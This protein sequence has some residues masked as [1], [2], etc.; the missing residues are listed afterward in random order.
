MCAR[1]GSAG[2]AFRG[3]TQNRMRILIYSR[4]FLPQIGG[5]ELNVAHIAEQFVQRGHE[6]VVITATPDKGNNDFSYPVLRKP[7]PL[8]FLRWMRWCDV[9]HH[10][11]VNLRSFWPLLLVPRPWVVT[12]HSWY[13]RPDGRIAWQDRLKRFVLRYAA[14]SIAVSSAIADDLATPSTVI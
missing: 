4:A 6:V 10:P 14:A 9:V 12:H 2:P 13:C 5:L 7:G 8:A 3:G 1:A 11:N